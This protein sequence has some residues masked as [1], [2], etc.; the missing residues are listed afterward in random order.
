MVNL[1]FCRVLNSNR[2]PDLETTGPSNSQKTVSH[3]P[4]PVSNLCSN[5]QRPRADSDPA[6]RRELGRGGPPMRVGASLR[7]SAARS[8]TDQA[9]PP[10]RPDRRPCRWPLPLRPCAARSA[11][12]AP[13]HLRRPGAS[14]PRRRLRSPVEVG[15]PPQ[16][17]AASPSVS[18]PK[19][20]CGGGAAWGPR[21]SPRPSSAARRLE[22]A[23]AAL[24]AVLRCG[25]Q[26]RVAVLRRG[27]Y[28]R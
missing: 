28:V 24:F 15:S 13:R 6:R 8:S 17:V 11:R 25:P 21:R 27:W 16:G 14:P 9:R 22:D 1:V 12:T 7:P 19:R 20:E 18:G 10:F 3:M 4:N 5:A 23:H 26:G 2:S